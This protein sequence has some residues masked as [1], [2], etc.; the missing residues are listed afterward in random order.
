MQFNCNKEGINVLERRIAFVGN[1]E[2]DC[3]TADSDIGAGNNGRIN[4]CGT[5][6]NPVSSGNI[7]GCLADNGDKSIA[8]TSYILLK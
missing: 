6:L 3:D 8:A 5:L 2:N 4:Y 7:A 1:N